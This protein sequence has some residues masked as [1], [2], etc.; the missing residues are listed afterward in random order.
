MSSGSRST[1]SRRG[2]T[3]CQQL[4][5]LARLDH[6]AFGAGLLRAGLRVVGKA[7]PAEHQL[8]P[9]IAEIEG[10]FAPLE[11]YVHR[12]HDA[13]GSQHAVVTDAEVR[14]VRKHDSDPVAW[15]ESTVCQD[16]RKTGAALVEQ[17]VADLHVVEPQRDVVG[18]A[19]RGV[20]EDACK[21]HGPV[22][23]A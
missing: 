23:L 19:L 14:D 10:D 15:L 7:L 13:T 21:V 17:A 2:S 6:D 18:V 16:G 5:E 11:Q 1:T 12:H 3:P 4:L 8:G 9:G 20:G 22:T